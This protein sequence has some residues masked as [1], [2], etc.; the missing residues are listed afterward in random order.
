MN[1]MVYL[2]YSALVRAGETPCT[3]GRGEWSRSLQATFVVRL[4]ALGVC[5]WL[6]RENIDGS[7]A[8][9]SSWRIVVVPL[10][11]ASMLAEG[12]WPGGRHCP[13]ALSAAR[14]RSSDLA[15]R[16]A[17]ARCGNA[18]PGSVVRHR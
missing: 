13:L 15:L 11:A 4:A 2:R 17:Q 18:L 16:D 1:K 5:V 10:L 8:Y 6:W 9:L 7:V 12:M 3:S 14:V